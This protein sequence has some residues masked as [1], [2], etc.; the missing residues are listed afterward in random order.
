MHVWM[1]VSSRIVRA[2][3]STNSRKYG[4]RMTLWPSSTTAAAVIRKYTKDTAEA[5]MMLVSSC[6]CLLSGRAN[7]ISACL[8]RCTKANSSAG[9]AKVRRILIQ[10]AIRKEVSALAFMDMFCRKGLRES[11]K[12]R[13]KKNTRAIL[14]SLKR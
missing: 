6:S 14:R 2:A 10:T 7:I 1:Q 9:R 3:S 4:R 5:K 13:M 11:P 12:Y 8:L